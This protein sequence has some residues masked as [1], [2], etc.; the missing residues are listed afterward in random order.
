M[1]VSARLF[2]VLRL[3]DEGGDPDLLDRGHEQPRRDPGEERG[4]Q[5]S[6]DHDRPVQ[7]Q[8]K[9]MAWRVSWAALCS[10]SECDSPTP[11]IKTAPNR[12]TERPPRRRSKRLEEALEYSREIMSGT[13]SVCSKLGKTLISRQV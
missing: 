2:I 6:P 4:E 8:G 11:K 1:V 13:P 9:P 7:W 3:E 5:D 10:R 12:H